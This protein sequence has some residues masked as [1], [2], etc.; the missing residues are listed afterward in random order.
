MGGSR[1]S[2]C[3][4][5]PPAR[6][7]ELSPRGG[8]AGLPFLLPHPALPAPACWQPSCSP[9]GLPAPPASS[10]AAPGQKTPKSCTLHPGVLHLGVLHPASLH[11]AAL[12]PCSPTTCALHL[13]APALHSLSSP[14][15]R[16][17]R[18]PQ[19]HPG[20]HRDE[21]LPSRQCAV[22]FHRCS[23]PWHRGC[24]TSPIPT[25]CTPGS[26]GS[27]HGAGRGERRKEETAGK[28]FYL[29]NRQ[30]G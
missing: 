5:N 18:G 29:S 26:A 24:A 8:G 12:Q 27:R 23:M 30:E 22:C 13:C 11:P 15:P 14:F 17:R 1:E 28:M 9:R 3:T 6:A 10:P 20:H 7:A 2:V 19:F 21:I 4:Q 25:A 16:V